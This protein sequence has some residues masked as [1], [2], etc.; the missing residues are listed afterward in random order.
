LRVT[1]ASGYGL[2]QGGLQLLPPGGRLLEQQCVLDLREG[3]VRFVMPNHQTPALRYLSRPTRILAS[4]WL[5][6]Q[7]REMTTF[8]G[9]HFKES[10]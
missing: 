3:Q 1:A 6:E 9:A 10:A 2:L 8:S 5:F 7:V 4:Y